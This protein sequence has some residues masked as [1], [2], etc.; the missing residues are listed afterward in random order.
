[1]KGLLNKKTVNR[2][3]VNER[4]PS[5]QN[6]IPV[7]H[8]YFSF[9]AG[10]EV[11]KPLKELEFVLYCYAFRIYYSQLLLII[12]RFIIFSENLVYMSYSAY[13]GRRILG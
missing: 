1:M 6:F 8:W 4:D 3:V 5:N 9:S 12:L 7:I 10:G 11:F 2:I 13:K